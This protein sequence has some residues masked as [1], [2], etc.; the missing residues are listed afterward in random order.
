MQLLFDW[1]GRPEREV[2]PGFHG[3]FIHSVHTFAG[4]LELIVEGT[5]YVCGPSSVLVIP[6]NARH[7]GRALTDCVVIDAFAPVREDY[8]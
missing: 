5:R 1:A 7:S 2:F 6:S 4:E 3:R 8:K